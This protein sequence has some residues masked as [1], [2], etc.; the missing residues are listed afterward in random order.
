MATSPAFPGSSPAFGAGPAPFTAP[1]MNDQAAAG[2]MLRPAAPQ[3]PYALLGND[4]EALKLLSTTRQFCDPGREAF[5]WGWWRSL[6]YFLGRQWIYWD[7]TSRT[8]SDKRTATWIPKPVTNK[9]RETYDSIFALLQD[10]DLG[11]TGRPIGRDG[12]AAI[13]ADLVDQFAPLISEEH[14]MKTLMGEADFWAI[15]LGNAYL[16]T[17]WDKDDPRNVMQSPIFQCQSCRSTVPAD[18]VQKAQGACPVCGLKAVVPTGQTQSIPIGAGRTI[19]VSPFELLL[20]LYAQSFTAVDRLIFNTWLPK[21]EIEELA[22]EAAKRVA[23]TLTPQQRSLQLYKSLAIQSDLPMTPQSWVAGG[24]SEQQTEG[25]T[26]QYLW[27]K[28]CKQYPQGVWLP[29][30]GEG[31]SAVVA[32]DMIANTGEGSSRPE[33]PY[34]K[35]DG[36]ALWPWVHY[37]YKRVGGRLYAQSAVDPILQKQDQINQID[38]MTILTANR[39]G[40]PVW[41]EEKGAQVERFTG[42]PGMVVRWQRV[43]QNGGEPKRIGGENPPQSFFALRQQYLADIEEA[44]GTYD[45]VKG[46]KPSGVEAFSALQLLVERSQ[47]RFTPVFKARGEAYRQWFEIA[48]ELERTYGPTTRTRA[49][50]GPNRAWTTQVFEATDLT[51]NITIVVEDGSTTPKT[52]LGKRAALEHANQ[53]G[54]LNPAMSPDQNYAMLLQLGVPE[55]NPTLDADVSS[56]LQEQQ[57]VEEWAANGMPTPA[58]PLMRM[59]W[60]DDATHFNEHRKW[61]NS[62]AVRDMLAQAGPAAAGIVMAF[63]N[64]LAEHEMMMIKKQQLLMLGQAGPDTGGDPNAKGPKNQGPGQGQAMRSSNA[65]SGPPQG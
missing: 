33:I 41:L 47:S 55:L 9:I 56:A 42:A 40:N 1:P 21:H 53:L 4:Q 29:F 5:E 3:D 60:H 36:S 8:W 57:L 25:A 7:P 20:P 62:D 28:A 51:G 19:V 65:N 2:L 14:D 43:G 24:G 34:K 13:T 31:D 45:V 22:P 6:L 16:H 63:G 12:K 37:P 11:V 49:I 26:V 52:A 15:L 48:L 58:P 46:A 44:T 23:W 61:M 32:R 38:S 10:I 30:I 18:A 35:K 17:F 39:M 50:L 54:L 59:P 64:H 27:I